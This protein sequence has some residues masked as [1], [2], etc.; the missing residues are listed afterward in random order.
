M[1][2]PWPR[3][4]TTF[5]LLSTF[6]ICTLN[7][8]NPKIAFIYA[9]KC[10]KN[11][12]IAQIM[13]N[14]LWLSA[15][16]RQLHL[17][18]LEGILNQSLSYKDV[19][20]SRRKIVFTKTWEMHTSRFRYTK[21]PSTTTRDHWNWMRITTKRITTWQFAYMCSKIITMRD[22]PLKKPFPYI[23]RMRNIWSYWITLT[24]G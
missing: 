15:I 14:Y 18:F 17:T 9:I 11:L 24:P 5:Q 10:W 1:N 19:L 2:L 4:K 7:K 16:I 22:W 3:H 8:T 21:R 20:N 6:L 23:L 13:K 12:R